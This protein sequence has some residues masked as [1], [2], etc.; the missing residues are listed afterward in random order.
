MQENVGKNMEEKR[1]ELNI[2]IDLHTCCK[3]TSADIKA[4]HTLYRIVFTAVTIYPI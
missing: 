1:E 2:Y 3:Y 4:M